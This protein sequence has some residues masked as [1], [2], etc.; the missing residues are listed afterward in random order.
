MVAI[1]V[2][3]VGG[4][5]SIFEG[6]THLIYPR[7]IERPLWS[8]LVLG[9]SGLFEGSSWA[10][11]WRQFRR[12]RRGRGVWETVEASKDPTTFAVLFEDS[13]ALAGLVTALVGVALGA[14]LKSSLPDAIASMIIGVILMVAAVL[15]ARAT[16]R[17]LVGQSADRETLAGIEAFARTNPAVQRV[18]RVL[19][20]H[21]G[22]RYIV[23]HV[24]LAFDSRLKA[25]QVAKVIDDLQRGLRERFPDLKSITVQ[26]ESLATA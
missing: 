14:A 5:M 19:A 26:A 7:V 21:F 15:L 10:V 2:F 23:A 6:V 8:F 9:L 25:E 13:A 3:A 20:V 4:G 24:E 1:L 18:A 11:A 12:E 17:L 22:P 16:L